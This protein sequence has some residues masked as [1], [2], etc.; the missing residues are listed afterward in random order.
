MDVETARKEPA[1][2][3]PVGF[4]RLTVAK[5]SSGEPVRLTDEPTSV[6]LPLLPA[7]EVGTVL[8]P[9][10]TVTAPPLTSVTVGEL[11][12]GLLLLMVE[13]TVIGP[14][15]T[16]VMGEDAF[17]PLMLETVTGAPSTSGAT[18][19]LEAVDMERVPT[20]R[21]LIA[22]S[23]P[24]GRLKLPGWELLVLA[25]DGWAPGVIVIT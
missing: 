4:E 24:A 1:L 7:S 10:L 23:D 17:V 19:E 21:L 6:A 14:R 25:I 8:T 15:E 22:V 12:V 2:P 20:E 16:I 9:P 11:P 3:L 13:L 5:D 18:K